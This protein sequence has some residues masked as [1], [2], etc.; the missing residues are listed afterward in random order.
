MAGNI[1]PQSAINTFKDKLSALRRDFGRT[2]YVIASGVSGRDNCPNCLL[3]PINDESS[4]VYSAESPYPANF[5]G[6]TSFTSGLCPVCYGVGYAYPSGF[7]THITTVN[8]VSISDYENSRSNYD[9]KREEFGN[10]SE[11]DIILTMDLTPTGNLLASGYTDITGGTTIFDVSEKVIVDGEDYEV[12]YASKSGLGEIF[13]L[14]V[15]C[16]RIRKKQ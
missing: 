16:T 3:D 11:V 9:F 4:G 7:S 6:P 15:Y 10:K 2:I 8:Y 13:T 1:I 5:P 12:K 14:R